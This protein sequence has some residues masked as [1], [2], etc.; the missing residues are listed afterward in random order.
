MAQQVPITRVELVYEYMALLVYM[1]FRRDKA[2]REGKKAPDDEAVVGDFMMLVD[3][4]PPGPLHQARPPGGARGRGRW[5]PLGLQHLR[6]ARPAVGAA[7]PGLVAP[8][9][10][11]ARPVLAELGT[12]LRAV[13][14][15]SWQSQLRRGQRVVKLAIN[16]SNYT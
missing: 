12:Q 7:G 15:T 1:R 3:K 14:N 6:A 11:G 13:S 10:A 9:P 4:A 8:Q 2:A 5:A 16:V